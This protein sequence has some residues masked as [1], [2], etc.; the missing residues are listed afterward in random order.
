MAVFQ[1]RTRHVPRDL[2]LLYPVWVACGLQ[3]MIST[4][5]IAPSF[6]LRFFSPR[7]EPAERSSE[8]EEPM[9]LAIT[10][11]RAIYF[12]KLKTLRTQSAGLNPCLVSPLIPSSPLWRDGLMP[13]WKHP[14]VAW[15][16]LLEVSKGGQWDVSQEKRRL[17]AIT[18]LLSTAAEQAWF[19]QVKHYKPAL[20][21]P[22]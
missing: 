6:F 12:N 13:W 3:A 2:S 17:W 19:L 15:R 16:S 5:Q 1:R 7:S 20:P 4:S 21:G 10:L 9:L 8:A 18:P 11:W 22:S 14:G